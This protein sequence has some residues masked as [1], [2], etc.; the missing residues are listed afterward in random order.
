MLVH[1]SAPPPTLRQRIRSL[2]SRQWI[3]VA[4]VMVAALG[5]LP[6]AW[7][8][9]KPRLLTVTYGWMKDHGYLGHLTHR[10][11]SELMRI[12]LGWWRGFGSD[13]IP[14]IFLDVKFKSMQ[15]LW[16]KREAAL[17]MGVLVQA[18]DDLVPARITVG[19]RT[20]RA[21]IR[22]K[23]DWTDHLENGHWSFRIH[24]RDGD[25]LF[26]QRRFSLQ[27]PRTRDFHG[28]P[29]FHAMVRAE[30]I[31]APRYRFV[32]VTLNGDDLG[33]MALEE[34]FSRE[35][36]ES[37]GRRDGVMLRFDESQAWIGYSE[38]GFRA[39]GVFDN[40]HLALI[41]PFRQNTVARSPQRKAEFTAAAGLLRAFAFG[42]LPA[43]AVFDSELLGRYLAIAHMWDAPHALSWHNM[44]FYYNPIT[45][46]LEPVAFD[47][48]T[49]HGN[50]PRDAASLTQTMLRDSSVRRS[51][52]S[53]LVRLSARLQTG[54]G[55]TLAALGDQLLDQ[56]SR[57]YPLLRSQRL[58]RLTDRVPGLL[59]ALDSIPPITQRTLVDSLLPGEIRDYQ[60]AFLVASPH[61][62]SLEVVPTTPLPVTI[63]RIEW[64]T[65]S[66]TV[67]VDVASL[68]ITVRGTPL[69]G[70]PDIAT[71]Q[72]P[73]P[74][75]D[76]ATLMISVRPPG[77]QPVAVT[78]LPYIPVLLSN[79]VPQ[80]SLA[81]A[82]ERHPFLV[83]DPRDGWLRVEPGA[84]TVAGSLIIP[85]GMGLRLEA[86]TTLDFDPDAILFV[87]GPT[88]FH[89]THESPI[90][91]QP[92]GG[93]SRGGT[94]Q[95]IVVLG[96]GRP[97]IWRHVDVRHTSGVAQ[98]AWTLTG[99]VTFHRSPASL[100]RCRFLGSVAEDALNIIHSRFTVVDAT[101]THT[102]SDGLDVD[103]AN[104][105]VDHTRFVDIGVGAGGDGL[106]VSGSDVKVTHSEFRDI[107]DKAISVGE[108]SRLQ[109]AD[110]DVM[111]AGVGVASKD[112]S[113]LTVVDAHFANIT[114]AA[115]MAYIKKPEY[116]P[117]TIQADGIVLRDVVRAAWI[118]H[119]STAVVNGI[120]AAT[121]TVNVDSLYETAMS[122]SLTP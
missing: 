52:R 48:M 107:G 120:A 53:A 55:D 39:D 2:S 118:Q 49:G 111:N 58:T 4:L 71:I 83:R 115:L 113:E 7:V 31:L 6:R 114:V 76:S 35:L 40:Y 3:G 108:Q 110:I 112:G 82:L 63:E 28:E 8:A 100:E 23:G 38:P 93:L 81:E 17:A 30:G 101:F 27:H 92:R 5:A 77:Y 32:D 62:Y 26:G 117:A 121:E 102:R 34:H 33:R 74:P 1:T 42:R 36:L 96:D 19:D 47:A 65:T 45:G 116:G 12:P 37:Q 21:R 86:G 119:G 70:I 109:A 18:A 46:R 72:L 54:L 29:L 73:P 9:L 98:G 66:D 60:Q 61:G 11:S 79:P 20:L 14:R 25:H 51:Y 75:A 78:A 57:Q 69:G 43:S 59:A 122:K 105:V 56:L 103:F 15:R 50:R 104:G 91:L 85:A 13:T 89:G 24:I 94:W 64:W 84:W 80:A 97:S 88:E 67:G 87:R 16:T 44:R 95:G 68:P 99:G 41:K 106:D 10:G 90:T 22:L